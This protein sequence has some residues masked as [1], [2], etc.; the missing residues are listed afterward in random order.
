MNEIFCLC[1]VTS[2]L[3]VRVFCGLYRAQEGTFE[4]M[5]GGEGEKA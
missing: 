4:M 2:L 5:I 1:F 3:L